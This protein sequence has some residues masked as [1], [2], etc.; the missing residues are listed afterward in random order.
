MTPDV[1]LAIIALVSTLLT[2]ALGG[3]GWF[4]KHILS[5]ATKSQDRLVSHLDKTVEMQAAERAASSQQF[6]E[7][8]DRWWA[9]IA[10]HTEAS[11]ANYKQ[12][13]KMLEREDSEIA[14]MQAM[15]ASLAAMNVNLE[16]VNQEMRDFNRGERKVDR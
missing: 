13:D 14:L 12:I 7:E 1:T 4:V 3:V 6:R 2:A 5:Q 15:S 11:K 8:R 16:K 10:E 9:S